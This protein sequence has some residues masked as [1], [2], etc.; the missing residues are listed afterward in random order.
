MPDLLTDRTWIDRVATLA[1]VLRIGVLLVPQAR[2]VL[3]RS[4]S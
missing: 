2:V 4:R 3:R 1:N